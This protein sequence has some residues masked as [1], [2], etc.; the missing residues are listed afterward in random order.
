MS[1]RKMSAEFIFTKVE[2]T[3]FSTFRIPPREGSKMMMIRVFPLAKAVNEECRRD[4]S[5]AVECNYWED[6]RKLMFI[7]SSLKYS[8]F[9][10]GVFLLLFF[11]I[12]SK[13]LDLFQMR[14][15]K[16]L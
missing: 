8:Q 1:D 7:L 11:I 10:S 14:N 2:G 3:H 15:Y 16:Y 4:D 13:S 12:L 9:F 6:P 5:L